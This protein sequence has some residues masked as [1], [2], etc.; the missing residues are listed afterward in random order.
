MTSKTL[1]IPVE[2]PDPNPLPATFVGGF[3]SCKVILLGVY[4]TA[5]DID[6]DERQRREVEAYHTLYSFANQFVQSGDTAEVELVMGEALE[7]VP[8]SVAEERDVDALLVPNPI[9]T[10]GRI[11]IPIRDP[12]FAEPIAEFVGTLDQDVL[13][14]TTLLHVTESE[15]EIEEGE[16]L[17]K[18]VQEQLVASDFPEVS[19]DTEVVVSDNPAFAIGQAASGHDLLIMGE[20]GD[21][22]YE[23]I[24]GKTYESIAE[25]TEL[26][27]VVVR[28]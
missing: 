10:L 15:E 26:P 13:I 1:L 23:R 21:P 22:T 11:L 5:D 18:D 28:E 24:F 19:I 4:E 17:L 6:P 14:H 25:E 16:E 27:V 7:D 8:S 12:E 2:F 3:T 20:T 9:T